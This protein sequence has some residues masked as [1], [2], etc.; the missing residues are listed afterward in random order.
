[1]PAQ[2]QEEK[3]S[4]QRSSVVKVKKTKIPRVCQGDILQNIDFIEYLSDKKG[5]IEISKITFPY[6]IILTQDCELQQD[7][8]HRAQFEKSVRQSQ[9]K[10]LLSVL[11][12]PLYNAE[13]VFLGQHLEEIGLSAPSINPRSSKGKALIQNEVPRYHYLDFP[14]N[15]SISSSIIDFKHYFSLN[16]ELL[17]QLKTKQ[18]VC[19][20]SELYREDISQRFAN[21]LSR[22]GLH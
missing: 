17:R 10:L 16:V 18:F 1:M 19:K 20:I 8:K 21:Y 6:V 3:L 13:H 15:I 7:Y 4:V 22:I 14:E 9:N 2:N 11:V 12:A 5:V